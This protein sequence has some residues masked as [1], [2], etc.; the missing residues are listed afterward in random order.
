MY[1]GVTLN[2]MY[3]LARK[4]ETLLTAAVYRFT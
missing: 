2:P 1:G 3:W 4:P